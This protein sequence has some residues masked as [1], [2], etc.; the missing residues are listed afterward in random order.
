MSR[1]VDAHAH[2]ML[3]DFG[4]LKAAPIPPLMDHYE[5]LGVEQV[6]F[7]SVD[8]LI[9]NQADVHRRSNDS[10]AALQEEYRPKIIGLAT[11]NPRDGDLAA[12]EVERAIGPLGLRGL[13]IHG[14]LQAVSSVDPCLEPLM[15]VANSLKLTVLF[16]DGT[17]PYAS[18]LQIAWLAEQ[19]PDCS[20]VLGHGGLKD[21]AENAVQA[22]SRLPN[23]Y[24]QTVG[25]TSL[26]MQ[27]ALDRVGPT[28]ILY[29]SDGGFGNL[30]YIDYNILKLQNWGLSPDDEALISGQNARRLITCD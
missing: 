30:K 29:G 12:R 28:R 20:I 22:V 10:L 26:G 18:T 27:R 9:Q 23:V 25:M 14:W 15:T 17:P 21:L 1:I 13:K 8:A 4:S 19:Y 6:W 3:H 11:V 7:S 5:R 2:I 24:L 16:H